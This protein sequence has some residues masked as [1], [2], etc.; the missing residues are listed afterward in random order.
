MDNMPNKNNNQSIERKFK[1]LVWFVS[2]AVFAIIMCIIIGTLFLMF[3][4]QTDAFSGNTVSTKASAS[5]SNNESVDNTS[6]S[7]NNST[8][9]DNVMSENKDDLTIS[10]IDK[11]EPQDSSIDNNG[12]IESD[13]VSSNDDTNMSDNTTTDS[14]LDDTATGDK[15][16]II[17]WITESGSKYH[18]KSSCSGMKSPKEITLEEA[19]REGYEPCKRCH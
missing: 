14:S 13:S 5:D 9:S 4:K 18:S 6:Q 12:T 15:K 1:P 16:D 11:I 10:S 7:D 19:E 17:V 3:F 2:G 8:A